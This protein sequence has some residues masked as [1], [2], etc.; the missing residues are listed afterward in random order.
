MATTKRTNKPQ[1]QPVL[2]SDIMERINRNRAERG[3][4]REAIGVLNA[5]TMALRTAGMKR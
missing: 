2:A 1:G 4:L 5:L 3:K